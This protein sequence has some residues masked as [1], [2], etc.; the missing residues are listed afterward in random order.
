MEI[1]KDITG[2]EGYYQVSNF[3]NVKSL[4]RIIY[5]SNIP[6]KRKSMLLKAK[7]SGSGYYQVCLQKESIRLYP[8]VHRLVAETFLH[9]DKNKLYV[10]HIDGSKINNNVDNL[11]WVT[12]SENQLH[13][14]KIGLQKIQYGEDRYVAKLTVKDVVEIKKRL[15]TGETCYRIAKDY[16][17]N[18]ATIFDIHKNKTWVRVEI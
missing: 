2:Y 10:N 3:G 11:E 4:D 7:I 6:R 8:L 15:K 16:P 17:V 9:K 18:Q 1:W 12:Q 5:I 14:Y 13:A